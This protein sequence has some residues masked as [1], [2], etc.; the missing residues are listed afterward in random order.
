[1]P[2]M[3]AICLLPL[4]LSV[5]GILLADDAYDAFA[6]DDLA[7]R[8]TDFDGCPDFH[9]TWSLFVAVDDASPRK[10]VGGQF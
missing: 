10:V 3:R 2:R 9:R 8:A 4:L 7:L 1:M 5:A 6:T